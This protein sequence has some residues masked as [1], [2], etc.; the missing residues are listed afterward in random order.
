VVVLCCVQVL[1]R[2]LLRNS[3]KTANT[4]KVAYKQAEEQHFNNNITAVLVSC[5][6]GKG[7]AGLVAVWVRLGKAHVTSYRQKLQ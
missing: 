7:W 2:C 4:F 6:V 3:H 1:G 5:Y